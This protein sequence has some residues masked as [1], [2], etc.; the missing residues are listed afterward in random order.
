MADIVDMIAAKAGIS[1]DLA[2]K[3]LGV[4]LTG[5][6]K[7]A[8]ELYSS[9]A[10]YIPDSGNMEAA[11]A[12]ESEKSGS[13]GLMGSLSGL[14]GKVLGGNA[15]DSAEMMQM[16]SK[17]GFSMDQVK[18]FAPAALDQLKTVVPAE[19]IDQVCERIPGLNKVT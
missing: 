12:A 10:G 1:P 14:A 7:F 16:F 19:I 4:I 18:D 8:P 17:A 13:G 5:L 11:Y 15:G 9:V 6:Q 3:G 2:R